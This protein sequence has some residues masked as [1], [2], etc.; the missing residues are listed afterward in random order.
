MNLQRTLVLNPEPVV[1]RAY[2]RVIG[3]PCNGLSLY[4]LIAR[5]EYS[6][7]YRWR[8]SKSKGERVAAEPKKRGSH[9]EGRLALVALRNSQENPARKI[10]PATIKTGIPIHWLLTSYETCPT[11]PWLGELRLIQNTQ[12]IKPTMHRKRT[13]TRATRPPRKLFRYTILLARRI[14]LSGRVVTGR[15]LSDSPLLLAR[16]TQS[17]KVAASAR[18][19]P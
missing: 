8:G 2:R 13:K 11:E 10:N 4:R 12:P 15:V 18:Y 16:A 6:C 7:P 14:S 3:I 17:T 5:T 9:C 19:S 1:I